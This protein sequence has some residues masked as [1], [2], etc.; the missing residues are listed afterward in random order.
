[1]KFFPANLPKIVLTAGLLLVLALY[2]LAWNGTL[3][4]D[5]EPNLNGLYSVSDFTSALRFT[6]QGVAGPTGRPIS[7][8][9]FAM[10]A[11]HWPEPRPFLIANT[12]IHIVNGLLCFL[13]LAR[14]LRWFLPDR[15]Q[16]EWLAVGIALI[17]TASPFLASASL[18]V[19]Q[20]MTGLSAFFTLL[21]LWWYVA[22]RETYQP[23][24]LGANVK[25][26]VLA[27]AGTLL[28][29]LAKENG[30]LL[31]VFLL[32]IERLLIPGARNAPPPLD[33]R[34]LL[35][36]L[37][38]PTV[39]ILAYL[40]Y[41][42]LSP[43]GYQLRDYT[44]LERLLTQPRVIFDYIRHLLIPLPTGI[45]PFHDQWQHSEG[46][47]TPITTLF[48]LLG[49]AVLGVATWM[50]RKTWPVVSFGLL[51]FFAG[52]LVESTTVPLELYYPHRNYI[53]AL[54][55]Y[56]AIAYP[57]YVLA[58]RQATWR[59]PA[60]AAIGVYFLLFCGVLGYGTSLWGNR[61]LAAEV[62]FVHNQDSVRAA[63]YLYQYYAAEGEVGTAGQINRLSIRNH[64]GNSMFTLQ[65]LAICDQSE[66]A[67]EEKV[68]QAVR[69]IENEPVIVVNVTSVIQ[70]IAAVAS[71]SDCE[72]LNIERAQRLIDAALSRDDR[73][74]HPRALQ[75]L[76]MSKAQLADQ[77]ED[78]L[79]AIQALEQVMALEPN[80]DAALLIAFYHVESGNPQAAIEHLEKLVAQPPVGFPESLAWKSR[81]GELLESLRPLGQAGDDD[82][83]RHSRERGNPDQQP[84]PPSFPRTRE[85]SRTTSGAAGNKTLD[86]RA[87][88]A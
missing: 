4:F 28:A 49:L 88:R 34:F 13:L 87:S 84:H 6:A 18:I 10:Q 1:M 67:F 17:W 15:R 58:M 73:F 81:L 14:L 11:E 47:F 27:G 24:Q 68:A 32:L 21:F 26:A 83:P 85:S 42:G 12:V 65:A 29:G 60:A 30:F 46:L 54:G 50:L 40:G 78:Y 20:R 72:H 31:P 37:V 82:R 41:R 80:L 25:L 57:L 9:A 63:Q 56:L 43:S 51:F 66:E 59:K 5:D 77:R 39:A 53:P 48:S 79:D 69:D 45:T 8:A 23:E 36:V 3:H 55:L 2:S 74:V 86:T 16:A 35:L 19:V 33:R 22:A 7:R 71:R 62:W 38:V 70:Q 61:M 64:P 52:H 44:V 75:N 76:L